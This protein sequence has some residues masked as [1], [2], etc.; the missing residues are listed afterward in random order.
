M[1]MNFSGSCMRHPDRIAAFAADVEAEQRE[2]VYS[3]HF[4]DGFYQ[5][6]QGDSLNESLTAPK[7]AGNPF[8]FR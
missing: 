4:F 8:N 3:N 5:G 7:F 6:L 2:R 1:Y